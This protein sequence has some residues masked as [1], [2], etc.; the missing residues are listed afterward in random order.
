METII[1]VEG[2][3]LNRIAFLACLG[4]TVCSTVCFRVA[5]QDGGLA[6]RISHTGFV[7]LDAGSFPTLGGR[8]QA[9]AYLLSQA[10]IATE[11]IIY[12]QLSRFGLRQK[13]LLET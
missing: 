12:A 7:Q 11:P 4:W 9:L 3:K 8:E 10:S 1:H 2:H 5:A 6:E 13:R